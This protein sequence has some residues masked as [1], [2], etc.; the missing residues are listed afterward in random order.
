M[1]F[2]EKSS[3]MFLGKERR[4]AISCKMVTDFYGKK[5][6]WEPKPGEIE[7]DSCGSILGRGKNR[8]KYSEG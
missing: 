8:C 1:C 4:V 7:S 6:M 3:R 5:V 2:S